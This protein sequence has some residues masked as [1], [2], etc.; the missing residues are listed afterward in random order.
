ME[1]QYQHT[2]QGQ[3][4]QQEDLNILGE[5]AALA[6]DRVLGELLRMEPT[7][8]YKSRGILPFALN[9]TEDAGGN[10]ANGA[11]VFTYGVANATVS[12]RGFRAVIGS[13]DITKGWR[14]IR[15][16]LLPYAGSNKVLAATAANDRWD[17]IYAR[18]DIDID[19]AAVERYVKASDGSVTK[20]NI[21]V[22]KH[23]TVTIDVV[24]GV[25]AATP[26]RPAVPSDTASAFYIPLAW[27]YLTHPHTSSSVIPDNAIHEAAPVL[28]ILPRAASVATLRPADGNYKANGAVATQDPWGSGYRPYAHLPSNMVGQEG[29]IVAM[30]WDHTVPRYS[31]GLN[32]IVVV[33][34]SRDWRNRVFRWQAVAD[35]G[36][37]P[38]A[39]GS[40]PSHGKSAAAYRADGFGQSFS[41][42][43]AAIVGLA[44]GMVSRIT[45]TELSSLAAS[46]FINL[47]VD[48]ATGELK[49]QTGATCPH[50]ALFLWIDATAPNTNV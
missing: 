47:F 41:N 36:Y 33:D 15:T 18:V 38:W 50:V 49:V 5:N 35:A 27:V 17:L 22:R 10:P 3:A 11:I 39:A 16:A 19:Q 30:H 25:E 42:D 29:L 45:P 8:G 9:S 43:A 20:Q 32:T 4:V 2:V 37:F 7:I 21:A 6:D 44:G 23:T 1:D 31:H 46:S 40:V 26:T 12:V 24:Q 13:R 28:P 48:Y 34:A 14:D